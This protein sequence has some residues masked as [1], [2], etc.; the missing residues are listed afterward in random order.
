MNDPTN[1]RSSKSEVAKRLGFAEI[2]KDLKRTEY[3][4]ITAGQSNPN[5]KQRVLESASTLAASPLTILCAFHA[6][7][8]AA[9]VFQKVDP[10]ERSSSKETSASWQPASSDQV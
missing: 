10:A 9:K 4:S 3:A 6:D 7:D 8:D 2:S 5:I 1:T